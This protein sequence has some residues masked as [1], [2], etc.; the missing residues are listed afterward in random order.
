VPASL[1]AWCRFGA[2]VRAVVRAEMPSPKNKKAHL[3]EEMDL[4]FKSGVDGT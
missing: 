4:L 2:N 1:A 3:S